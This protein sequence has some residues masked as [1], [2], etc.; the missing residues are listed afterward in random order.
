MIILLLLLDMLHRMEDL[1]LIL[2]DIVEYL[3]SLFEECLYLLF[4]LCI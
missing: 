2:R 3:Y 1:N 4:S